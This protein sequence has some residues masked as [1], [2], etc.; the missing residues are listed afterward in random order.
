[1]S[2]E[3]ANAA[4]VAGRPRRDRSGGRGSEKPGSRVDDQGTRIKEDNARGRRMCPQG[5][6]EAVA[7]QNAADRGG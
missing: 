2:V 7:K 5:R 4:A 3:M 6:K 1:M